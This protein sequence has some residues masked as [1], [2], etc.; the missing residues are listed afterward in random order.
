MTHMEKMCKPIIA[1][2]DEIKCAKCGTLHGYTWKGNRV[3]IDPDT[4]E[5]YLHVRGGSLTY[6]CCDVI[7]ILFSESD[8]DFES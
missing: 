6:T 4:K 1:N 3:L 2:G 7:V 5:P 8:C